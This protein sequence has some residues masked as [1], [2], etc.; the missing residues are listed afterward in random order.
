MSYEQDEY[1]YEYEYGCEYA[2]EELLRSS[3]W[4]FSG[5]VTGL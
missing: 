2:L 1:E 4:L 5:F 3:L